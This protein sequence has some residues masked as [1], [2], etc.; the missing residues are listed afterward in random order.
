ML[1]LLLVTVVACGLLG[2]A[3]A[4]AEENPPAKVEFIEVEG[5]PCLQPRLATVDAVLE[6]F[7]LAEQRWLSER[8]PGRQAHRWKNV[9]V[10]P[11]ETE[12]GA[13]K[14]DATVKTETAF[15]EAADGSEIPVCF[16]IGLKSAE[17]QAPE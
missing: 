6:D 4:P 15:V 3:V 13:E 7:R 16:E 12:L 9:L 14:S 17:R 8:Y 11:A 5:L 2:S 1:N 10:L